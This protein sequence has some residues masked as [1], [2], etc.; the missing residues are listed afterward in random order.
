MNGTALCLI[1]SGSIAVLKEYNIAR[2]Y[3][4]KHKEEYKNCVIA[5]RRV[6]ELCR[7]SEKSTRTVSL[8]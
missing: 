4:T 8:L 5:L 2:H 6:Q 3:S 7:C 1:C